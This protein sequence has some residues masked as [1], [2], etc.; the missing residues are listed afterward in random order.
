MSSFKICFPDVPASALTVSTN[1][2]MNVDYPI[3]NSF[4]GLRHNYAQIADAQ[5]TLTVTYDLGTGN[6]R[7]L[8]HFIIG[9][10]QII[11]AN[12]ITECRVAGSNNG[13]A[14]TDQLGTAANYQTRTFDG[15]DDHDVIFVAGYNDTISGT[16][17]AYRYFRLTITGPASVISFSKAYFGAAFDMGREPDYYDLEVIT[18]QDAD[19]WKYSRGHT[20][21]TKAYHPKHR[22]TFEWDGVTDAKATEFMTSILDNPYR[23]SVFLYAAT[24]SDPLYDNKLIFGRVIAEDCEVNKET[25]DGQDWNSIKLVVEESI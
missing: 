15:P 2:T 4:Y 7:T 9:G 22:F 18:E 12:G 17:A 5:L 24:Y 14:W 8:D 20:L 19:T 11:L 23:D 10:G 25:V 6:S 13:V 1:L 3:E 16:L 21:M